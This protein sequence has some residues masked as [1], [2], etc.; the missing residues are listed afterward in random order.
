MT[1]ADLIER[2][3]TCVGCSQAEAADMVALLVAIIKERLERGETVKLSSF[4]NFAL[5][6]KRARFGCNPQTGEPL[7]MTSR[8]ARSFT[9]SP[10]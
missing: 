3:S 4:G 1:T 8:H 7:T 6:P 9:A 10:I 2:L 5:C